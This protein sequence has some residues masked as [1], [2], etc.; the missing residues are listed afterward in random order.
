MLVLSQ[1]FHFLFTVLCQKHFLSC[2]KKT[3]FVVNCGAWFLLQQGKQRNL[4]SV[5]VKPSG[6]TI[7]TVYTDLIYNPRYFSEGTGDRNE[8]NACSEKKG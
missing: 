8:T 6:K 4:T 2:H 3:V 5:D 7:E 1:F